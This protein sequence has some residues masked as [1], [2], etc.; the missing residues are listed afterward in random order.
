MER[1][2]IG[3]IIVQNTNLIHL[4]S[5]SDDE[6]SHHGNKAEENVAHLKTCQFN[7]NHYHMVF[8]IDKESYL[9]KRLALRRARQVNN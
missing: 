6:N 4:D 1:L 8:V 7:L 5:S 3:T 2:S 9:Y